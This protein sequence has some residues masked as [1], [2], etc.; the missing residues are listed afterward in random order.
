MRK[1]VQLGLNIYQFSINQ[2]ANGKFIEVELKITLTIVQCIQPLH[3]VII[4]KRN[5]TEH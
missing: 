5:T 3:T 2:M 4:I 1:S